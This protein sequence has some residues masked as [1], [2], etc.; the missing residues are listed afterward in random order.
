MTMGQQPTPFADALY[1]M[2]AL[3]ERLLAEHIPDPTGRRC[4]ACTTAGTGSP[5]TAWPCRIRDAADSARTR[6]AHARA[7]AANTTATDTTGSQ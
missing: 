7:A 3:W 5:G 1:P 6:W 4:Q 2:P